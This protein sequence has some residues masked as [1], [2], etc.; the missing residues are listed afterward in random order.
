MIGEGHSEGENHP[1]FQDNGRVAWEM[2]FWW[3][4]TLVFQ[5]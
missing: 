1:C 2:P 5:P 3:Q 4:E